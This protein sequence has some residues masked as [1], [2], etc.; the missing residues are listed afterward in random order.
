[1]VDFFNLYKLCHVCDGDGVVTTTSPSPPYDIVN[2]ECPEC[3]GPQAKYP[4]AGGLYI[5]LSEPKDDD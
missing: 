5:G 3:L 4:R 2:I 1:M